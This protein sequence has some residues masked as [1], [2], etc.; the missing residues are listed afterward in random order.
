[1]GL[2]AGSG[3][4]LVALS[5]AATSTAAASDVLFRSRARTIV[6]L[7]HR[8]CACVVA[9]FALAVPMVGGQ[10]RRGTSEHDHNDRGQDQ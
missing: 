9:R 1:M 4:S 7:R 5:T 10:G 3:L 8:R 2:R 6:A